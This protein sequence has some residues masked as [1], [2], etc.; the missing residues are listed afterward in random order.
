MGLQAQSNPLIQAWNM[1]QAAQNPQ[2]ALMD[3]LLKGRNSNEVMEVVRKNNGDFQKAFFE[4]AK[5]KG[6]DG[7][8]LVQQLQSMGLK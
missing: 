1:A 5:M 3:A 7:N 6:T 8:Q 2:Q 4:Y